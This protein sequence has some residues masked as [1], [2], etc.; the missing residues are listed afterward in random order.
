VS[1]LFEDLQA[2]VAAQTKTIAELA[3]AVEGL[4]EKIAPT[5]E[6]FTLREIAELPEAPSL[7]SLQNWRSTA[8]WKLP[9]HGRPDGYSRNGLA[10]WRRETVEAW[11]RELAP[12]PFGRPRGRAAQK[13]N[14][15]GGDA[16]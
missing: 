7:K 3:L 10:A 6:V 11:R 9:G 16:A 13:E 5:R 12:S 4:K 15:G 2:A 1:G 8:P 14:P